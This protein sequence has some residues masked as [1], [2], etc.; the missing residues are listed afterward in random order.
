MVL[1]LKGSDD[2]NGCTLS[3]SDIRSHLTVG[4]AQSRS[5][6]ATKFGPS[7]TIILPK[8]L[9]GLL[10]R[11]ITSSDLCDPCSICGRFVGQDLYQLVRVDV[12]A[13]NDTNDFACACL[14]GKCTCNRTCACTLS[15]NSA[16]FHQ[17]SNCCCNLLKRRDQRTVNQSFCSLKHVWKHTLR[18]DSV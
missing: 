11:S 12:S 10:H 4:F 1:T 17:Q 15:Y 8:K 9:V 14:A 18:A 7:R 2:E 13:G 3:G 6:T 5:P 16:S